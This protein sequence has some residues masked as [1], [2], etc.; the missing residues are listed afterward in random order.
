MPWRFHARLM[1]FNSRS[2]EGATCEGLR[3][4]RTPGDF[5][6]RSCEGATRR[7]RGRSGSC[8]I[9]THAPVKERLGNALH[10]LLLGYFNSRSC[11]GAT[12]RA[13]HGYVT[14]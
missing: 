5:N 3:A 10:Q 7:A 14:L 2:C 9:S 11:E 1:D 6:S 12:S 4:P 13:Q 8:R